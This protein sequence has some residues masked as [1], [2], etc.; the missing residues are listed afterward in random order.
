LVGVVINNNH[1]TPL[2]SH[3]GN[4]EKRFHKNKVV[5]AIV[6]QSVEKA[7]LTPL[8]HVYQPTFESDGVWAYK[9]NAFPMS[10]MW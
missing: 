8:I 1:W 7:A 9:A 6:T 2:H 4:E 10:L 5:E 3:I